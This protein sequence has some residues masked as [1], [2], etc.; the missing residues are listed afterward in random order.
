MSMQQLAALISTV[1]FAG[2]IWLRTRAYYTYR[3]RGRMQ[4]TR[5]GL[6]FFAAALALLLLG[7]FAAPALGELSRS[8][9]L[10]N[11]TATRVLWDIAT[12]YV[13]IVAH[14]LLLQQRVAVFTA[15]ERL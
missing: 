15:V 12:Y 7:W 6:L 4:L 9:L 8:P 2:M 5:A 13:F 10:L 1:F 3:L 14:R 11:A